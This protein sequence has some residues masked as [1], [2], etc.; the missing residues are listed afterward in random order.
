MPDDTDLTSAARRDLAHLPP[1]VRHLA[2]W[3]RLCEDQG[4][5]L[6][7]VLADWRDEARRANDVAT[8]HAAAVER[9]A[10]AAGKLVQHA[11]GYLGDPEQWEGSDA[12]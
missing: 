5:R 1:G 4:T 2:R 9:L 6:V 10:D 7:D 12:E 8:R 3:V 11:D